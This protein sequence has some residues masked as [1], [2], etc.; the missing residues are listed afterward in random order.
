MRLLL[1]SLVVLAAGVIVS[2]L[3]YQLAT[4]E[5]GSPFG[6]NG[7]NGG[8]VAV[9]T[10]WRALGG[11]APSLASSGSSM[12]SASRTALG[13]EDGVQLDKAAAQGMQFVLL[14]G[15]GAFVGVVVETVWTALLRS[16]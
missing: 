14:L 2:L 6:P 5:V 13:P 11:A 4:A 8:F 16:D 12:S 1:R 7:I 15:L 9:M 3:L 10:T